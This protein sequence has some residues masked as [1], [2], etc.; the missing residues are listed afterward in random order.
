MCVEG[1]MI[2]RTMNP[3]TRDGTII[4]IHPDMQVHRN[5]LKVTRENHINF[6]CYVAGGGAAA[7]TN[8]NNA[9]GLNSNHNRSH[10]NR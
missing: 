2:T 3:I 4:N 1:I 10:V 8:S 7:Q 6:A 9:S 5:K